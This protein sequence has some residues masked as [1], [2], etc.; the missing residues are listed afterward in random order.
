MTDT[1]PWVEKYRPD[2]FEDI[3]LDDYNRT[4]LSN[5]LNPFFIR[6][7]YSRQRGIGLPFQPEI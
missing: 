4:I 1:I 7:S 3:V 6:S 2:T 5:L